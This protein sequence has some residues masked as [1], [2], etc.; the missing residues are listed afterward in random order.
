MGKLKIILLVIVAIALGFT[1][2]DKINNKTSSK[3]LPAKVSIDNFVKYEILSENWVSDSR[4]NLTIRCNV[5]TNIK[6][7]GSCDINNFCK[8]ICE[9]ELTKGRTSYNITSNEKSDEKLTAINGRKTGAKVY[10]CECI[11]VF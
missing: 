5:D 1:I 8:S 6:Y 7:F 2:G 11:S 4:F 9:T 10:E 3:Y